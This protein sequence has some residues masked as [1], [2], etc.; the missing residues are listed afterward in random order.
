MLS[1]NPKKRPTF[2][3][4]LELLKKLDD[5]GTMRLEIQNKKSGIESKSNENVMKVQNYLNFIDQ[6]YDALTNLHNIL[7]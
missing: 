1:H 4:I 6:K 5:N 2:H 3:D 7:G